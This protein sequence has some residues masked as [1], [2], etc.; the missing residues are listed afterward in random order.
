M[1]IRTLEKD[2]IIDIY[3]KYLEVD[4]PD[5]ELK[6]LSIML[7][8]LEKGIYDCIG[9]FERDRILA[10]AYFVHIN[11][12]YLLDYFAVIA[13][14]RNKGYGSLFI[15][16]LNDEY[17]ANADSIIVEVENPNYSSDDIEK[18]IMDKRIEFYL[19]NGFINTGVEVLLFGVH[20]LIMEPSAKLQDLESIKMIYRNFYKTTLPKELYEKYVLI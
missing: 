18:S 4:F 3:S 1:H 7:D 20:Y 14:E 16:L 6:P 15:S 5:D 11:N 19:N 2:E 13:E 12:D 10:Y 17:F 9:L 8:S